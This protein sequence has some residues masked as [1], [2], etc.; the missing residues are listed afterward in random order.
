[1]VDIYIEGQNMISGRIS[2]EGAFGPA[3]KGFYRKIPPCFSR[4]KAIIEKSD[5]NEL[6]VFVT[7]F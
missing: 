6:G 7:Y 1:M 5:K 3:Y 2:A 4:I